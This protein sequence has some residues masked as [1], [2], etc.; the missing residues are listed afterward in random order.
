M[1]AGSYPFGPPDLLRLHPRFAQLRESEPLSRVR[2]PYGREGWLATRY[3]DVRAIISDP[4]FSRALAAGADVPRMTPL[5]GGAGSMAMMDAPEHTRMRRLVSKA[6]SLRRIEEL[7]PSVT[8]RAETLLRDLRPPADLM[9]DFGTPL[10]LMTICDMLGVP[11]G[12]RDRFGGWAEVVV[13]TTAYTAE[14]VERVLGEFAQYLL[15]LVERRRTVPRDDLLSELVHAR[16]SEHR[17]SEQELVTFLG[18]SLTTGQDN[19]AK[20]VGNMAYTL[21]SEPGLYRSLVDRPQAIARA[22]EELLRYL[23]ISPGL[24]IARIATE[25]VEMGGRTIRAGEAVLVSFASANRDPG[26]FPDPEAIDVEREGSAHL[27]FGPGLHHCL[28]ASLVRM[29]LQEAVRAL[30]RVCPDLRL[31]VP[32]EEVEWLTTA[33]TIGPVRLPV[34]W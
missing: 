10:A 2:M 11:Y 22:V 31:A 9:R 28:A 32:E 6:F 30:V 34:R 21:L 7:R 33:I 27:T 16:D 4:R 17:L 3:E 18:S 15:E 8:A 23:V 5:P 19:V 1:T 24:G 13:T 29:E 14:E 26:A 25:D 12:E 20:Q